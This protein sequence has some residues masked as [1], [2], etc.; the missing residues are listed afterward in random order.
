[1][2]KKTKHGSPVAIGHIL[3]R[4]LQSCRGRSDQALIQVWDLWDAAVGA[5]IAADAQ[6]EAFKG[7]ILIVKVSSSTWVHHLQ[8]FKKDIIV[9]INDALGQELVEEIKFKIGTIGA[10]MRLR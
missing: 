9:K 8:F 2:Q 7:K 4:I 3:P 6:P 10:T 5:A 1:M